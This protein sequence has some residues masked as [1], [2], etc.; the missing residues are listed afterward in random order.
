MVRALADADG[1]W[2]ERPVPPTRHRGAAST[3][4]GRAGR[5]RRRPV[6]IL[7]LALL[8]AACGGGAGDDA[9]ERDDRTTTTTGE[10]PIATEPADSGTGTTSTTTAGPSTTVQLPAVRDHLLVLFEEDQAERTGVGLP[11]GTKLPPAQDYERLIQLKWIIGQYGW[12]TFDMV[13]KDGA[14]AAWVIAQHAD[15]DVAFQREAVGHLRAAVQAG[16]ADPTELAYLL[17]RVAVNEG[18]PQT[19]ATQIRCRGGEPAPA[20]PIVDPGRIDETRSAVG[21]GPLDEYYDELAMM[22]ANE[23]AEGLAPSD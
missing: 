11:E 10:R 2:L 3:S 7:A 4:V 13:G 15:F 5:R 8:L 12:P 22:C 21:L 1:R 18:T 23:E 6:R 19:Y 14:T 20:T 9:G 16:Q 17:D